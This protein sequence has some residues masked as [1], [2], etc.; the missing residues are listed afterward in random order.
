MNKHLPML[1]VASQL[2]LI[3]CTDETT[4]VQQG[5]GGATDPT[6]FVFRTDPKEAYLKVDRMGGPEG[7]VR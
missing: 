6:V 2:A 3:A 4:V 1:I 5:T 7:A